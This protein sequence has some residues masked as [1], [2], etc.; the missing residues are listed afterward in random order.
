M[1]S[2]EEGLIDFLCSKKERTRIA[3]AP[4]KDDIAEGM[5]AEFLSGGLAAH[6]IKTPS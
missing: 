1:F 3:S 2:K 5:D 4:M 6:N